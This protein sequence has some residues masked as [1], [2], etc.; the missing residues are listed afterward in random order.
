MSGFRLLG[1]FEASTPVPGGKPKALLARLLL[2]QGRVLS[3]DALVEA[4]WDDPPPSAPKILQGH[5][6][7]LRKALGADA[8]E[9]RARGYALRSAPSDLA[10]F[11]ELTEHARSEADAE[12]RVRLLREAL[13]LWRGEPLAEFRHEPFA[14]AAATRLSELRL[15]ALVRRIESEIE[16]GLHEQL[17]AELAALVAQEPLREQLRGLLMLALY[18][19]GRQI[20]ALAAYRDGRRLMAEELGIEPGREL[21]ALER[22][23]LQHD[24]R[25]DDESRRADPR[26][27][28]V[29]VGCAPLELVGRLG[30]EVLLV[31]LAADAA[32]LAAAAERL[33]R[34][35]AGDA[36]VRTVCFTSDD[37]AA[38]AIR[39]AAEQKAELLVV[40]EAT[41]GLVAGSPCDVALLV[42]RA[43][44]VP[45]GS[46]VVPFGGAGE[47]W[48]ALEVA[49]W[50]ARVH[51]LPLRLLGAEAAE[52]RRDSSRM[53]AAA[54][55]SLQRFAGIASETVIVPPGPDGVLRQ[56]GAAIV[57]SLPAGGL[58]ATRRRIV[59]RSPVPVLLVHGGPRPGGLAPDR[60][61]TRYSWTAAP[62]AGDV[63]LPS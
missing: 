39:L 24:P 5:V 19:S 57:A 11:E 54:S 10:R 28:V 23:I 22:A 32:S 43:P 61:L 6:S 37:P 34:V 49:A 44:F 62:G 21:Q 35:R 12:H 50:L 4:L 36:R 53:L 14:R 60:T 31:E 59:E 38:D 7:A 16:L 8:I 2:E 27:P 20:D 42:Q 17:V 29:C 33:E 52:G 26:G 25:L 3:V 58:D 41:R 30:R 40:G 63:T 9:T 55:L 13:G 45:R 46:V 56:E 18:R 1:P 51:G 48:P 47:D 15:E